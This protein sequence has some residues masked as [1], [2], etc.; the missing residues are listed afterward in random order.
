MTTDSDI[1]IEKLIEKIELYGRKSFELSKLKI[2]RDTIVFFTGFMASCGT[3]LMILLFFLMLSISVAIFLGELLDKLSYG[4]FIVSAF[5]LMLF[6]LSYF[7]IDKY[8][9]RPLANLIIKKIFSKNK[10]GKA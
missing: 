1:T 5:Y 10:N 3:I 6:G 7:C 2:I 9:K 8:I 4:F